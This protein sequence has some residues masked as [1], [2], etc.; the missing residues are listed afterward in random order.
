[1]ELNYGIDSPYRVL[2]GDG[3]GHLHSRWKT[4]K[5]LE[6]ARSSGP[7]NH[8]RNEGRWAYVEDLNGI[9]IELL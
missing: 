2:V 7:L 9:G 4:L 8:S 5:A 1:M 6:E 3:L